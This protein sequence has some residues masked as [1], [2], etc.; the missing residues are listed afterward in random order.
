[1]WRVNKYLTP[2]IPGAFC[3]E[4]GIPDSQ[5]K[6]DPGMMFKNTHEQI[7]GEM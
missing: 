5:K 2:D 6:D 3:C 4:R 1:M 7:F